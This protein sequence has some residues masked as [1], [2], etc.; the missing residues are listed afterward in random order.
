MNSSK[1][2]TEFVQSFANKIDQDGNI[3]DGLKNGIP[4]GLVCYIH[5]L[6]NSKKDYASAMRQTIQL[7]SQC[8]L[9]VSEI[10][11]NSSKRNIQ[12]LIEDFLNEPIQIPLCEVVLSPPISI[13]ATS[14]VSPKLSNVITPAGDTFLQIC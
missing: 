14:S 6:N 4:S 11:Y 10:N 9:A 7:A 13:S 2:V 1:E 5:F 12:K 3:L 8:G